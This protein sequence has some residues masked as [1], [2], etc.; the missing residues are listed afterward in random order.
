MGRTMVFQYYTSPLAMMGLG[1][2][3]TNEGT[4]VSQSVA[5]MGLGFLSWLLC[6][7]STIGFWWCAL[8]LSRILVLIEF[9]IGRLIVS[10]IE[11][12]FCYIES[13][14]GLHLLTESI[15]WFYWSWWWLL[16]WFPSIHWI[17]RKLSDAITFRCFLL[18]HVWQLPVEIVRVL[19]F[20][21]Y[22]LYI[23]SGICSP[24][25]A[26]GSQIWGGFWLDRL[27]IALACPSLIQV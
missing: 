27:D 6:C 3:L 13:F 8:L 12:H 19:M 21:H 2:L 15:P 25:L 17:K 10:G 24:L 1:L 7:C 26:V 9:A 4:L 5:L 20:K 23:E 11:F 18:C 14:P 22:V 16:P